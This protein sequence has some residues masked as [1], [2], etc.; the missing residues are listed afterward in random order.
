MEVVEVGMAPGGLGGVVEQGKA[1]AH[2][3]GESVAHFKLGA[4]VVPVLAVEAIGE[5]GFIGAVLEV[6]FGF[7]VDGVL[8]EGDAG[9][10]GGRA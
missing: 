2:E 10:F 6:A 7:E 8:V 9:G 5:A 4:D 1:V 3:V